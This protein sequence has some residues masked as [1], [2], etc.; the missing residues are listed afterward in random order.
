MNRTAPRLETFNQSDSPAV[1]VQHTPRTA[2]GEHTP[3]AE[4]FAKTRH[5]KLERRTDH[6]AGFEVRRIFDQDALPK[7]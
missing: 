6:S 1:T 3:F 4:M 5:N 2:L 7:M